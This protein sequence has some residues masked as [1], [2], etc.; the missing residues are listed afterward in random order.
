MSERLKTAK[1]TMMRTA[2]IRKCPHCILMPSHY[3]SDGSC[4][5]DDPND[6]H[7]AEWEYTW[8]DDTKRWE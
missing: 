8:N 1:I 3:R 5:C 6:P 7:M 2:D 4:R